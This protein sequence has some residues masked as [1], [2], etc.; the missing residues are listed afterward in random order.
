MRRCFVFKLC[1]TRRQ[2]AALDRYLD[3]TREV[4]N[5][6]LEQRRA[7]YRA[8]GR[9]PSFVVQSR[10]IKEL[11]AD[12]LLE[13]VHVHAVQCALK[14]LDDAYRAFFEGRRRHPRFRS[15]R[16][17]RSVQFKQ[18]GNGAGPMLD[19]RP[20]RRGGRR[21][22]VEVG[23]LRI[24][25]VG[26]VRIRLHRPL[27]GEPK[28]CMLVRKP[29][30]WHAHI[31]CELG[32]TPAPIEL[33]TAAAGER[34]GLD[35]GVE[36]FVRLSD[37]TP[38]ENPRHLR[39]VEK[40]LLAEQRALARR[41]RGSR[42]RRKQRE[43]VARAHLKLARARRDFHHKVARELAERFRVVCVEDLAVAQLTRSA[44]GTVERPGRNVAQKAGLN[45][46]ILDCGWA[47][48]LG[49]LEAKLEERGGVLVRVNP[50]GTSQA[51]SGCGAH[52]PKRLAERWHDCPRCGLSVHRD[53]NAA[54]NI[55]NR[56]RARPVAEAA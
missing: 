25:G 42:R 15:R 55:L 2:A 27:Q 7:A 35:L 41:R 53:T 49:I 37:D 31:V 34:V 44:K 33:E 5:S 19:P 43:R 54:R 16:H 36:A 52:V 45:R 12:G 3:A 51:C 32:E 17:W 9:S 46:A 20:A 8:T 30:G 26:G 40:R 4:Y 18:W 1:P 6:A 14:R 28:T 39:H 29:D 21:R 56:A 47:Q 22:G 13:G 24:A 11:R 50:H 48:F 10:E 23:R 38:I